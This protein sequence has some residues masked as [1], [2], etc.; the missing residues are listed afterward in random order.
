[1]CSVHDVYT[2][3]RT[4]L[5]SVHM[6]RERGAARVVVRKVGIYK[7]NILI[8]LKLDEGITI[9]RNFT[10]YSPTDQRHIPEDL[11]DRIIISNKL[12]RTIR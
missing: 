1:M 7:K 12:V 6:K 2:D 5:P 3:N 9:R 4:V 8:P 10:N 11:N